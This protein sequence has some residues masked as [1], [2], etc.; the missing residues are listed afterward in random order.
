M[1]GPICQM[2]AIVER[3][4]DGKVLGKATILNSRLGWLS[5]LKIFWRNS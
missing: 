3:K 5:E 4:T 1:A 2:K